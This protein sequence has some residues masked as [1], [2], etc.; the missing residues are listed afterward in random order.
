VEVINHIIICHAWLG[1]AFM[2]QYNAFN[3]QYACVCLEAGKKG[4]LFAGGV[5]RE[6]KSYYFSIH[7]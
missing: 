2:V 7:G 5:L 1:S 4:L 6:H 3:R